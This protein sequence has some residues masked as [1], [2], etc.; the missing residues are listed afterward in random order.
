MGNRVLANQADWFA[1]AEPAR[2]MGGVLVRGPKPRWRWD[3]ERG[4]LVEQR[5]KQRA[6]PR[7]ASR[8]RRRR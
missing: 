8:A 1:L 4:R 2:W 5:G 6:L 7:R 3:P